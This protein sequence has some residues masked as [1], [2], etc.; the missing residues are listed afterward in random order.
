MCSFL[1]DNLITQKMSRRSRSFAIILEYA[2]GR[3][4]SFSR[5]FVKKLWRI[6]ARFQKEKEH[7]YKNQRYAFSVGPKFAG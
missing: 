6:R 2:V 3:N 5:K 4:E 1:Q 7:G